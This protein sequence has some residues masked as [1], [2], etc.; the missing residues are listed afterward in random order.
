[1][2]TLVHLLFKQFCEHHL[3]V[4]FF[5]NSRWYPSVVKVTQSCPTLVTPW[6]AACKVP[7]SMGFS[8]QEYWSRLP[9][10]YSKAKTRFWFSSHHSPICSYFFNHLFSVLLYVQMF[11]WPSFPSSLIL[12]SLQCNVSCALTTL[13]A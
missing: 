6:T 13:K 12:S 11:S 2:K 10:P 4:D 1:M 7:L 5:L 8:K 9:F 3:F